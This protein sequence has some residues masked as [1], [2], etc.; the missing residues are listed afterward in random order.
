MGRPLTPYTASLL[1]AL[2]MT[3]SVCSPGVIA[4]LQVSDVAKMFRTVPMLIWIFS[5]ATILIDNLFDMFSLI[6]IFWVCHTSHPVH[7][8]ICRTIF[9]WKPSSTIKSVAYWISYPSFDW[10]CFT[11]SNHFTRWQPLINTTGHA[12]HFCIW[13]IVHAAVVQPDC[14]FVRWLPYGS[15]WWEET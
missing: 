15:K 11:F 6:I 1:W 12:G 9:S 4:A 10:V 8:S 2:K 5:L 14:G 3:A 13:L 7:L